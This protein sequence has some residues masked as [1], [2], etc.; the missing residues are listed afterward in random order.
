MSL[1]DEVDTAVPLAAVVS[2]EEG[3]E[4]LDAAAR[5]S[6]GMSGQ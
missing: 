4:L 6:L 2:H 5:R 3:Q 1:A